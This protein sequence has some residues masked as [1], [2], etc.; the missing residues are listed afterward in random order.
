MVP[1][2]KKEYHLGVRNSKNNKLLGFIAGT[3]QYI[4]VNGKSVNMVDV[5]DF[6][7]Y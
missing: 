3:P 1:E 4:N 2:Y 5:F 7:S 6:L